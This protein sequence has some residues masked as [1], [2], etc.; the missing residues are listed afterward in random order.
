M[1]ALV[2][3]TAGL[4]CQFVEDADTFEAHSDYAWKDIDETGLSFVKGYRPT[5]R[6]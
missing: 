1:K 6:F 4:V 2:H 3:T 5:P